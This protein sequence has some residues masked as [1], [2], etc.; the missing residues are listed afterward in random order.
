MNI[1]TFRI[2]ECVYTMLFKGVTGKNFTEGFMARCIET[3]SVLD[4]ITYETGSWCDDVID[5]HLPCV[6]FVPYNRNFIDIILTLV[7]NMPNKYIEH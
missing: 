1:V 4:P 5:I 7:L 3:R 6:I 2:Y